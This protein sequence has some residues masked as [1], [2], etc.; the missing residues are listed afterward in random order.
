M[1]NNTKYCEMCG[2]K[3]IEEPEF[4]VGD[5]VVQYDN[6]ITKID[7]IDELGYLIGRRYIVDVQS[8]GTSKNYVVSKTAS[9]ATPEEILEYDSALNFHNHGRKP[10][11]VKE[12][13]LIESKSGTKTIIS[14]PQTFSKISFVNGTWKL[15]KTSEEVNEWL[16]ASDE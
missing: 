7:E 16:G 2:K 12:G 4:K 1:L 5:Y 14:Y 10:F 15:P 11:K 13:D 3:L 9:I 6:Y 8:L